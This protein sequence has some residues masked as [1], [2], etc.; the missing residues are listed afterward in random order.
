MADSFI[1]YGRQNITPEDIDSVIKV[2]KSDFLTQGP[3][4][5][6]FENA[7]CQVVNVK[8]ALSFNSG[9]SALHIA[10]L[11]LE[12]NEGDYLWTT[13][14]TFVASANCGLYCGAKV[15]FVDINPLTG[16]MCTNKLKQKLE[17][18]KVSGTLPKIVVPVH[19]AGTSCD[20]PKI[21]ELSQEYGFFIIEDASHAIG[22]FCDNKSVGSCS[23]SDITIFSFHPV[24]IITSGEGGMA[25]TN[26]K[27]INEKMNCLRTHGIIYDRS[28]FE[29]TN[30]G[31]WCYEQHSLGY[32]YRMSDISAA[33]GLSQLKRLKEFIKIRTKIIEKYKENIS[34][35]PINLL[36]VPRNVKS[37]YHLAI[38]RLD[39]KREDYHRHIYNSLRSKNI[40][41]QVHYTPVH[42]QPLYQSKGFSSGDYPIAED[43]A[44]NAISLPLYP[45]LSKE[46]FER[47]L[48]T[49]SS[50]FNE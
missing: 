8:H 9:T 3:V 21:Y 39:N 16:L 10:C 23:F 27:D 19:L 22:G 13:P 25:T 38:I 37:A 4:V 46:D 31:K 33:L 24:K 15:D 6:E 40:G 36:D 48:N 2:L 49:L 29:N 35:L 14:I 43:Y 41:V 47:V 26:N 1:P 12:L 44:T 20:M 5:E 11:A 42:M 30:S 18:A 28:L 32:N 17:A 45:S 7:I 34:G 50:I